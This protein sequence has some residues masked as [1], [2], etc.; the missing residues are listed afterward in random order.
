MNKFRA[1]LYILSWIPVGILNFALL[2]F[3]I[4]LV[5]YLS[6]KPMSRWPSWTW[7]WQNDGDA[8]DESLGAA[9]GD[10]DIPRWYLKKYYDGKPWLSLRLGEN[11]G[12][13]DPDTLFVFA[14]YSM[15]VRRF[16]YMALRNPVNNHRF[17]FD[18]VIFWKTAGDPAAFDTEGVDLVARGIRS[19]SGWRWSGFFAGYRRIWLKG[20]GKYS[21]FYIGWKVGSRVPGLG[22]TLQT[23]FN[24]DSVPK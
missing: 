11:M 8:T 19:A 7:I 23:R 1:G 17:I 21:E 10:H 18:D 12:G 13:Y 2:L 4:P 5:G 6:R 20:P 22:F 16:Q 14:R 3:G 24:R 9:G 15:R